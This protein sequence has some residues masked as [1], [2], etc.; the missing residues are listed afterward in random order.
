MKIMTKSTKL[1]AD[2]KRFFFIYQEDTDI[3]G[4]KVLKKELYEGSQKRFIYY[5]PEIQK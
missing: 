2:Y 4:N 3:Y 5:V 1:P